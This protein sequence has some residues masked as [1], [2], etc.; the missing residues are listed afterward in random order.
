MS[1]ANTRNVNNW[2]EGNSEITYKKR[3]QAQPLHLNVHT[4]ESLGTRLK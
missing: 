3:Y 1:E 2:R 4:W